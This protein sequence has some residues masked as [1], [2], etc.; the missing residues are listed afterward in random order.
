MVKKVSFFLW[1]AFS[2]LLFLYSYVQVDLGLTLN[3]ASFLQALQKSFQYIGYF[4]RPLSAYL[5]SAIFTLLFGL[6]LLTLFWVKKGQ[7]T[8]KTMIRI[9]VLVTVILLFSYNAFSYDLFNY[10][11]DAKIITH[12]HANP[13][14]QKALDYPG[15][16]ML[17]FMHWTHRT[18]PY[19]PTWLLLTVPLSFMGFGYFLAT[20]FLF[21]ALAAGSF[22][23]S[24]IMVKKIS[25]KT[26]LI[27]PVF[28]LSFFALNPFVL[29]ESLVSGH[30]DI[31]MIALLLV[32]VYYLFE[33]KKYSPWLYVVLSIGVKFA[34]GLLLPLFLWYAF[35]KK[36]RHDFLFFLASAILMGIAVY[37]ASARTTFQPWYFL[38]PFPF[39][40][41]LGNRAY[42]FTFTVTF[43]FLILFQYLP[44]I[45]SGNYD[46]PIP[47]LMNNMLWASIGL[48]ILLSGI[49]RMLTLR[50]PSK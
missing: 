22:I 43:S 4:N 18:Y 15:D 38:L 24:C 42:I 35:F 26:K 50:K 19:G 29:I 2:L 8:E 5:A 48:S 20:F 44:Y 17:G 23:L 40:T 45:Y 7:L 41:F 6:Y 31:A 25:E 16:P 14:F 1:G 27:Q 11:F 12:Y 46:P 32:G 10:I 36:K 37:L 28:A 33:Q 13:Y 47:A 21:K 39:L 34:T 49:S 3:R 9:I 30:N